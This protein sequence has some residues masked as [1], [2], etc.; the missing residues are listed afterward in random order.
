MLNVPAEVAAAIEAPERTV[1][2][3]LSV[4][5][6]ADGHGPTGSID[7]LSTKAATIVVSSALQGTQP[8]QAA[9]VEGTAAATIS[10]DLATGDTTDER[11]KAVRHYSPHS[12]LS[13]LV[14]KERLGR[15]IRCDVEFLTATGW[16]G[17]PLL[18]GTS[19]ALQTS[20]AG[21]SVVLT[22]VD[23]RS[24]LRTPV[25]LPVAIAE[26]PD[27]LT[28]YPVKPGLEGTW[29]ISYVLWQCGLPLSPPPRSSCR[30]MVPMHGSAQVFV[31]PLYEGSPGA[32]WWANST[33]SDPSRPI[34]FVAGPFSLA[35]E[36]TTS[37]SSDVKVSNTL[38]PGTAMFAS[39]GRSSGRIEMWVRSVRFE[40]TSLTITNIGTTT[41][42]VYFD[43]SSTLILEVTNNGVTR[44][45]DGPSVPRDGAWHQVGVHWDDA[46]GSA[47]FLLDQTVTVV[48]FTST[49]AVS[50][51]TDV[52]PSVSFRSS[53]SAAEIHVTTGISVTEP[54]LP[55]TWDSG[56]DVDRSQLP[57]DGI[58]GQEAREGWLILQDLAAAEQAALYLQPSGRLRYATRAQLVSP[59]AQVPQ[60]TIE[61]AADILELASDYR[62]DSVFNVVSAPYQP[63][64]MTRQATAWTPTGT[65]VVPARSTLTVAAALSGGVGTGFTSITGLANTRSDGAGTSYVIN[66][67]S[68]YPVWGVLTMTS[69]TSATI[70][71]TNT[72]GVPVWLVDTSGQSDLSIIGDVISQGDGANPPVVTNEPSRSAY[73]DQP[74]TM[75]VSQWVQQRSWAW[76]LAMVT[77]GDLARP[78]SVLTGLEIPG[79]PRLQPFDRFTATDPANTELAEDLWYV[80]GV[81]EI[82]ALGEYRQTVAARPARTRFLAGIGLVG[83]DLVG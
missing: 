37:G 9:V 38:G 68:A 30:W 26:A 76:G 56:C 50:G 1:R 5:W 72:L 2:A 41:Q 65:L 13:P 19:R 75:P 24:R 54:W 47:S 7:D 3:R 59:S 79:D 46:A 39:D 43:S 48:A 40:D 53:Q 71:I 44:H 21:Q 14:G 22:G 83:I 78:S 25:T 33:A 63:V 70:T 80:G 42:S 64:T 74:L 81:H 10:V 12:T 23:Y 32:A 55:L 20:V 15:D 17:V 16:K 58:V 36:E 31:G 60:R 66:F 73:G 34:E 49:L 67:S 28:F 35:C 6:D 57:L 29:V 51:V 4:D 45:V 62:L 11:L 52:E 69:P 27:Y 82:S 18:R 61:A 77:A 8:D